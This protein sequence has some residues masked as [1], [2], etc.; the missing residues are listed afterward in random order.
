MTRGR[1][2]ACLAAG[3]LAARPAVAQTLG[4]GEDSDF[5]WLRLFAALTLC[6]VL[7]VAA[8]MV[9]RRRLGRPAVS[10]PEF[11]LKLRATGVADARITALETRRLSAQVTVSVFTCDGRDFMV[12]CSS[13]GRLLLVD[14]DAPRTG[15]SA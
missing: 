4:G 9:Q 7:A 3:L 8:V 12:A 1:V 10:I 6:L 2:F 11:W 13:Q 15:D 14:L 5:P